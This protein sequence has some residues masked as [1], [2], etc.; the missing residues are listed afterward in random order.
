MQIE[1]TG[2]WTWE[3]AQAVRARVIPASGLSPRSR[4]A[5]AAGVAWGEADITAI[6]RLSDS[7]FEVTVT[8][9]LAL[10]HL[11]PFKGI[12]SMSLSRARIRDAESSV[13]AARQFKRSI[14]QPWG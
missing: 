13:E 2:Y 11:P 12:R 3:Q 6:K 7:G 9:G 4:I 1:L 14:A 8:G 5:Q 10:E